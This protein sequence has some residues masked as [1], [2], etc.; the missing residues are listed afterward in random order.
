[1][2]VLVEWQAQ[3][4]VSLREF[5]MILEVAPSTLRR[6]LKNTPRI[7]GENKWRGFSTFMR[8][9]PWVRRRVREVSA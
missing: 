4:D 5:A 3:N 1:M 6:W 7:E 8:A 9:H 2:A